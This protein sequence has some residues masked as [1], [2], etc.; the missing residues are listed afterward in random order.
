M[1]DVVKLDIDFSAVG[2]LL[3]IWIRTGPTKSGARIVTMEPDISSFYTSDK[4][5]I[6]I[7]WF[8]ACRILL[9]VLERGDMSE[10]EKYPELLVD[11]H[12]DT[13]VLVFGNREEC[14]RSEDMAENLTAHIGQDGLVNR[15]TLENASVT[16]LYHFR[17][18]IDKDDR[19][20]TK[21]GAPGVSA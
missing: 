19:E 3:S 5:L 14:V 8:D 4:K 1:G 16:L 18:P 11:Y 7:Y 20:T 13:D 12:P 6:G 9:P 2:D 15:F 10:V 17:N 21:T